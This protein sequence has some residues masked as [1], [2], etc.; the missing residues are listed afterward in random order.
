MKDL[1]K[2]IK[3]YK[4]LGIDLKVNK[5]D[6]GSPYILIGEGTY[7]DD[8]MSKSKFFEG[9]AGFYS[10]IRFDKSGRFISQEFYE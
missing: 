7:S 10:V 6:I 8:E 5:D 3:L 9:Y 1:T 4:S 2:F